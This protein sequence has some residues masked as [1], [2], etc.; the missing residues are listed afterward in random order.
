MRVTGSKS[1]FIA[2][3]IAKVAVKDCSGKLYFCVDLGHN[4]GLGHNLVTDVSLTLAHDL[5]IDVRL[6]E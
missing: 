1:S 4:H 3:Y 6:P 2:K 5:V